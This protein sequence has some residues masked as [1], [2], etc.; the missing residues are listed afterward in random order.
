MIPW[1]TINNLIFEAGKHHQPDQLADFIARH[2]PSLISCQSV[3]LLLLRANGKLHYARR[4]A[5]PQFSG[6]TITSP[7]PLAYLT[8]V[9][10]HRYRSFPWI[11]DCVLTVDQ[12]HDQTV[13]RLWHERHIKNCLGLGLWDIHGHLRYIFSLT[14]QTA[15]AF[16]SEELKIGQALF[17]QLNNLYQNMTID[18]HLNLP[19]SLTKREREVAGLVAAGLDNNEIAARLVISPKTVATHLVHLHRKF[20]VQSRAELLAALYHL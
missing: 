6:Q 10:A 2:L 19:V 17:D 1:K 11:A 8:Q 13:Q 20:H 3:D 18:K 7:L 14:R 5:D 9:S 4:F 15:Q 16:T 12:V